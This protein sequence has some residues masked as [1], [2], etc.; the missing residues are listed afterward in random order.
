VLRKAYG[1]KRKKVKR[2]W[3]KLY[4]EKLYVSYSSS[5][6]QIKGNE[7]GGECDTCGGEGKCIQYIG[8]KHE[9]K[10]P[11]ETPKHRCTYSTMR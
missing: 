9:G 11:L 3:I 7:V 4:E 8:G 5:V 10:S 2:D 1:P 6:D